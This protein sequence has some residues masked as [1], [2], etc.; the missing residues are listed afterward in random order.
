[1][2]K[3]VKKTKIFADQIIRDEQQL[4]ATKKKLI[5]VFTYGIICLKP[6]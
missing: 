1:M 3:P 6:D 2:S 4:L 5:T